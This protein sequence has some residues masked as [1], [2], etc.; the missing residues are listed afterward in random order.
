MCPPRVQWR[1]STV[2]RGVGHCKP[3]HIHQRAA[4][5]AG[6]GGPQSTATAGFSGEMAA[7]GGM[8]AGRP[9]FELWSTTEWP[10]A[11]PAPQGCRTEQDTHVCPYVCVCVCFGIAQLL[12]HNRERCKRGNA[13]T[14]LTSGTRLGPCLL[15]R[16]ES[17][18]LRT[19]GAQIRP[20]T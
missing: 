11:V 20:L 8:C 15:G 12:R 14:S 2:K 17:R 4:L 1:G 18:Y 5:P 19:A 6:Q 10:R 13:N 7:W 16:Q 3:K 9:T